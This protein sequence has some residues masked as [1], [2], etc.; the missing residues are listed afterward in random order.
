MR[1]Y[2]IQKWWH[3]FWG[4]QLEFYKLQKTSKENIGLSNGTGVY[5]PEKANSSAVVPE[6]KEPLDEIID[7]LNKATGGNFT[8]SNKVIYY[9]LHSK[10]SADKKLRKATKSSDPQVFM[11]SIFPKLFDTVAQDSYVEQTETFTELFKNKY[12]AIMAVLAELLYRE[13]NKQ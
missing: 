7:R 6:P 10:L 11:E 5:D 2:A 8:E 1:V 13:F 12:Y 9:I 4:L 3:L